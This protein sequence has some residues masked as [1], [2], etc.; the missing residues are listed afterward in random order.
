MPIQVPVPA[1]CQAIYE[2]LQ[3]LQAERSAL[4]QELQTAAPGAKA[5]IAAQIK[6]LNALIAV[7]QPELDQ[8]IVDN[9]GHQEPL[10][11]TLKGSITF[12]AMGRDFGAAVSWS[13][14][15]DGIR[16]H[17]AVTQFPAIQLDTTELANAVAGA[18]AGC[19]PKPNL[20]TISLQGGGNGT[21]SIPPGNVDIPMVLF[22]DHSRDVG[23]LTADSSVTLT[24][25]TSALGG[26]PVDALGRVSL[27]GSG[28]F[29]QG[30]L[31]SVPVSVLVLGQITPAP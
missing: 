5:R 15:F 13:L 22:F 14:M 8:C 28:S 17:V 26:N 18:F 1:A 29:T 20:T 6:Q 10:G 27:A 11:A 2:E 23:P 19:F 30:L 4:Q 7:K 24:L 31:S 12:S 9:V 25:S 21:C 16:R 3:L